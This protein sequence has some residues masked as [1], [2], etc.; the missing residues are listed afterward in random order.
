[1]KAL[2][3]LLQEGPQT[4][5]EL[6]S[7]LGLTT[8]AVTSVVDRLSRRGAVNRA[9]HPDDGR[10]VLVSADREALAAGDN[11]YLSIG[12]A[13]AALHATFST[14]ELEF[15]ERYLEASIAVT[16]AEIAALN[17]RPAT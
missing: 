11:V 4:P 3:I 2:Q 1:M 5:G 9:P 14:A 15:L 10:K 12:A 8:G 16:Q 13:Y 7:R 17:R 6:A